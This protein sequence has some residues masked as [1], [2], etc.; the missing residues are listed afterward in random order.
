VDGQASVS[1]PSLDAWGLKETTK[2]SL[3]RFLMQHLPDDQA[4]A[5]VDFNTS[6]I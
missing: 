6:I 1:D 4:D 5:A 3:D 2:Q